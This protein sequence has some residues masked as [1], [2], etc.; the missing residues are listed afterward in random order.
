MIKLR[1]STIVLLAIVLLLVIIIPVLAFTPVGTSVLTIWLSPTPTP[2]PILTVRGTPP[3]INA[4]AAYVLDADSGHALVDINGGQRLPMAST[5]KIMTAIL[6]IDKA[7]LK[8]MVTIK[9]NAIDEVNKNQGSSAQLVVGD[10]IR[11][12]DLLYALMLPSGDDAA[13]AIAE[14]V[15]GTT[16]DFVDLMNR[17]AQQLHL[18]QTHYI[19]P[20]GLTYLTPE[21]KPN[22]AHYTTT[23]DLVKLTRYA[24]ANPLFAQIVQLQHYV[25]HAT[26]VHHAYVWDNT[27]ILLSTYAGLT[28]VKTGYTV[29]AG[30]CLVFAARS[31]DHY[32]IGAILQDKDENQRF[33]DARAL[34]DW[35]FALPM[36]S[37]APTPSS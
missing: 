1:R 29:E 26:T 9:Q 30:Y 15:S 25:L 21:G 28:G 31:D 33:L 12:K 32:L 19:N 37:P 27:N 7:N 2:K 5:T 13:I 11:L 35:A 4:T 22:P 8:Q 6:T 24:L 34:L 23:A 17:Y 20:D 18:T 16:A 14:A 3:A 10:Q 36:G